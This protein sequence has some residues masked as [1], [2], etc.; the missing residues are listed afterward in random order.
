[1]F[2]VL[3]SREEKLNLFR[4]KASWYPVLWF[5]EKGNI[6]GWIFRREALADGNVK[7]FSESLKIVINSCVGN[8][9]S[10]MSPEFFDKF[11]SDPIDRCFL[12]VGVVFDDSCFAHVGLVA[13]VAG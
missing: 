6:T 12:E 4:V 10:S 3:Q 5:F 7:V 9:V 11:R 2:E 13:V 1:M 8:F